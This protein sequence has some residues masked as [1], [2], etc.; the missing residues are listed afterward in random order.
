MKACLSTLLTIASYIQARRLNLPPKL[1]IY[2]NAMLATVLSQASLGVFTLLLHVPIS[3]A[4]LHQLGSVA[5][6]SSVIC[7]LR[8]LKCCRYVKNA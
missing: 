3:L 6:L 4:L 7:Y 1:R 2:S 8:K 5:A